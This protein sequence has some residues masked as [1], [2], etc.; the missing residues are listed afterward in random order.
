MVLDP[1]NLFIIIHP[2]YPDKL[3][4]R[5]LCLDSIYLLRIIHKIPKEVDSG[6]FFT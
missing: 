1:L 4:P 3:S 6:G 2:N 5:S